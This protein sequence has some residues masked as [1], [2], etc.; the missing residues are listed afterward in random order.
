MSTPARNISAVPEPAPPP[1][2]SD[3]EAL[4]WSP[5]Y[6]GHERLAEIIRNQ[7]A[8]AHELAG[9]VDADPL[10]ERT[11][12]SP[13][14]VVCFRYRG[15]DDD[16]RRLLETV[17][18][19][20]EFFLSHTVLHGRYTLHLAIGNMGTTREHVMRAWEAVKAAVPA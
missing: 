20:G 2:I 10:F 18:A 5:R 12:P 11:A 14:S 1:R 15:T 17:N 16:N 9:A 13:L 7:V 4:S 19:A 6:F 3:E 8:W